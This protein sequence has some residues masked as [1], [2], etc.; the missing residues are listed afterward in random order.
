[1]TQVERKL[2]VCGSDFVECGET[3]ENLLK[4]IIT[5]AETWVYIYGLRIEVFITVEVQRSKSGV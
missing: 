4:N 3:G 2:L 1:L 5:G